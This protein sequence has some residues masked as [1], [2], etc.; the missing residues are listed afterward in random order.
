VIS[1]VQGTPSEQTPVRAEN[2]LALPHGIMTDSDCGKTVTV[3][4]NGQTAT[5]IV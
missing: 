5:G 2:V 1:P 3:T 4:Y